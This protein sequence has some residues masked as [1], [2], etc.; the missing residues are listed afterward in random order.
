VNGPDPDPYLALDAASSALVTIDMQRDFLSESPFG[1]PG[2][3]EVL[4]RV[5]AAAEAF[6]AAGRPVVHVVR[7][8]TPG[9][10]DADL[11]RRRLLE[12]GAGIVAPG[13]PGAEPAPGLAPAGAPGLDAALLMAGEPQ[14]LGPAEWAVY[15]PRWGAFYRTPLDALL[16]GLG[17]TS[18]VFAGCNLPNCPRASMIE[19]SE[20]DYRVGLVDD[21]ISRWSEQGVTELAGIGVR[22]LRLADLPGFLAGAGGDRVRD[23]LTDGARDGSASPA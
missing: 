23:R 14:P 13:S 3:T 8:Y 5:A 20:R 11:V 6:R 9:G 10:A 17:V 22:L 1:V 19:A 7:Y 16:R 21:A 15:K 4:P 2:T 18:L 12:S